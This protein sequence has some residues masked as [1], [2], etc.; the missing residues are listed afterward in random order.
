M[1]AASLE[2]IDNMFHTHVTLWHP[3]AQRFQWFT[4][5]IRALG[6]GGKIRDPSFA[7]LVY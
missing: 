4:V 6:F 3:T 5:S 7:C 2:M 1:P